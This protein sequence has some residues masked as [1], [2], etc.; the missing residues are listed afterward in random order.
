M[1]HDEKEALHCD[2]ESE[3][4]K[5]NFYSKDKSN[6]RAHKKRVH[7][8]PTNVN[9]AHVCSLCGYKTAKKFNLNKHSESCGKSSTPNSI[10]H[11]CNQCHKTFPSKKSLNR[12]SKLHNK[13]NSD[14][15]NKAFLCVVCR[16][17]FANLWNLERHQRKEHGLTEKGN[18]IENSVGIA[19]F[20]TEALVKETVTVIKTR[21]KKI[22]VITDLAK[23][24]I[25]GNTCKSMSR[26]QKGEEEK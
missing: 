17:T 5:C 3:G 15:P 23:K 7:E 4:I 12:H 14:T 2:I 9:L 21:E 24:I 26:N 11:S 22:S 19:I 20:T 16:K 18:V 6:L 10:D 1:T 25:L 8:K 13:N